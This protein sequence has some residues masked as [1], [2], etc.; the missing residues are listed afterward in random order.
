MKFEDIHDS[1]LSTANGFEEASGIRTLSVEGRYKNDNCG[2]F[3]AQKSDGTS[4]VFYARKG[5]RNDD[6]SWN[7][8]CPSE[9][10]VEKGL[11][12][13]FQIYKLINRVNKKMRKPQ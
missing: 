4:T 6:D 1:I 5:K 10:E 8:F 11:P 12:T 9:A 7:W 2:I 13:L 3:V